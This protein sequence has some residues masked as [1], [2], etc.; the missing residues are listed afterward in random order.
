MN[1]DAENTVGDPGPSTTAAQEPDLVP[2][3]VQSILADTINSFLTETGYSP[4]L[5]IELRAQRDWLDR[6]R[7]ENARLF[8]D[9]SKLAQL[10]PQLVAMQNERIAAGRPV[11]SGSGANRTPRTHAQDGNVMHELQQRIQEIEADYNRLLVRHNE[12]I[13]Q[14]QHVI[15][16]NEV[17]RAENSRLRQCAPP[18]ELA[19]HFPMMPLQAPASQ[20]PKNALPNF[21]GQ[22]LHFI[23]RKSAISGPS[24]ISPS[25]GLI[26][27]SGSTVPSTVAMNTMEIGQ[28]PVQ[29]VRGTKDAQVIDLTDDDEAEVKV[30]VQT[31]SM[32]VDTHQRDNATASRHHELDGG[33]ETEKSMGMSAAVRSDAVEGEDDLPGDRLQEFIDQVFIADE[34]EE[35]SGKLW[36]RM[37]EARHKAGAFSE[38]PEPFVNAPIKQLAQHWKEKHPAAWETL[39]QRVL[40]K[41]SSD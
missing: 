22:S 21:F 5:L 30:G 34:E 41:Q 7:D 36:C 17:L 10:V 12:L 8:H 6:L 38:P 25:N 11:E 2:Q 37:C 40:E 32:D 9:N 15:Q 35:N 33:A 13:A 1:F 19:A 3:A 26:P 23:P 29:S 14:H 4:G 20:Q 39:K 28:Q 31:S 24:T 27:S 16:E 18:P